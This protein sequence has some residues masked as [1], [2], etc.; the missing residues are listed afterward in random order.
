V[1]LLTL[2]HTLLTDGNA[3]YASASKFTGDSRISSCDRDLDYRQIKET[4]GLS[5][6][7]IAEICNPPSSLKMG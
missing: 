5:D 1:S 2:I 7:R 4:R 6:A 3:S